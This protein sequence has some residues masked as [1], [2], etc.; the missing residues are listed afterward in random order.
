MK[1]PWA[2]AIINLGKDVENRSWRMN[3]RG[4]LAIHASKTLDEFPNPLP[5]GSRVSLEMTNTGGAI[6]GA[7]EVVD[8]VTE[9]DSIWF[10]GPFGLVLRHPV[11]LE[12]P[13]ECRGSLGFWDVPGFIVDELKPA[14]QARIEGMI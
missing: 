6:I 7:V 8:C 13:I 9:S 10:E 14:I 3:F 11:K 1:Q 2:Y 12:K 4:W 5:D